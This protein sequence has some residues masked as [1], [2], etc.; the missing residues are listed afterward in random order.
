MCLQSCNGKWRLTAAESGMWPLHDPF[1]QPWPVTSWRCEI[2][3]KPMFGGKRGT[4]FAIKLTLA[5]CY[6]MATSLP[7]PVLDVYVLCCQQD[8]SSWQLRPRWV[9]ALSG[10]AQLIHA[11][12]LHDVLRTR[13]G[14]PLG[15][16]A[17]YVLALENASRFH[18]QRGVALPCRSHCVHT[19]TPRHQC[20]Q[21]L[22]IQASR[23]SHAQRCRGFA[24]PKNQ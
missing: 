7:A 19:T 15:L 24:G 2:A 1:G 17:R 12:S 14:T 6:N 18:P 23:A 5:P 8:H 13:R 10:A 4:R 20:Q 21:C 22:Q 11:S 3:G 9:R 16:V